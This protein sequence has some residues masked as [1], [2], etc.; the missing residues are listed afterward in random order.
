MLLFGTEEHIDLWCAQWTQP[1]GTT[2]TINQAWQLAKAWYHNKMAPDW[3]RATLEETEALPASLGL[4]GPFW[5][6]RP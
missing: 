1:R 5:T 3:R 2:L 6:L 4:T